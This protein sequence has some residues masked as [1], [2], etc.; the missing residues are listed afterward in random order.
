MPQQSNRTLT[1]PNCE[2]CPVYLAK[3]VG[4]EDYK[5]L[6]DKLS[7][8]FQPDEY[9]ISGEGA[10]E[11]ICREEGMVTREDVCVPENSTEAYSDFC[12]AYG[13]CYNCSSRLFCEWSKDGCHRIVNDSNHRNSAPQ[14]ENDSSL[15]DLDDTAEEPAKG[16]ASS[17]QFTL[18]NS[19]KFM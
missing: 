17:N 19:K 4:E 11:P 13:D 15:L 5:Q 1:G 7:G 16:P 12:T 10:C 2:T 3:V 14:S 18:F 9:R 8:A 6:I